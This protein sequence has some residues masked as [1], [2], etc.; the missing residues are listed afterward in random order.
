M[1]KLLISFCLIFFSFTASA[2]EISVK[3]LGL[4]TLD[5][6]GV[7]SD[8]ENGSL[9]FDLWKNGDRILIE[10]LFARMPEKTNSKT[11]SDIKKRLLLTSAQPPS[12]QKDNS[13][14]GLRL[15]QLMLIDKANEIDLVFKQIPEN[16]VDE[17]LEKIYTASL[18]YRDKT[19]AGCN[20]VKSMVGRYDSIFWRK[21]LIYCQATQGKK[22]E[23]ELGLNLLG[24]DDVELSNDFTSLING[25]DPKSKDKSK[26]AAQW[27]EILKSAIF[28]KQALKVS[29]PSLRKVDENLFNATILSW[30]SNKGQLPEAE[31]VREAV[32]YYTMLDATS[33][34]IQEKDWKEL[35]LYF[36]AQGSDVPYTVVT[37]MLDRLAAQNRR[38]ETVLLSLYSIG[39]KKINEL[40]EGLRVKIVE[41]LNK[42]GLE[43]EA[44]KIATEAIVE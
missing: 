11:A 10:Q 21:S 37:K 30:W 8:K 43:Q 3:P 27:K 28:P 19:E 6:I 40:P 15:K 23:A 36:M 13:L 44:K 38:G 31:R 34:K 20:Y 35:L 7:L 14:I 5:E 18:F 32:K 39:D 9:G 17:E 33:D 22:S 41:S 4:I 42:V 16:M 25:I 29:A 2:S 1:N 12:G 24:E 26:S